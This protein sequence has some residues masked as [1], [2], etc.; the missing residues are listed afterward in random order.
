MG[1][2]E[3]DGGRAAPS[4]IMHLRMDTLTAIALAIGILF[5][6]AGVALLL[7]TRS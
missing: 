1:A 2:R 4:D 5:L 7:H 3:K 6:L